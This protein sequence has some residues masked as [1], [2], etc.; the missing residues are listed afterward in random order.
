MIRLEKHLVNCGIDT[1]K[2]IKKIILDGRVTVN[3]EIE[4]A[5]STKIDP[6]IDTILYDGEK[7]FPKTLKYYMMNKP[8]GYIT[9]VKH[10]YGNHIPIMD[11]F[12]NEI[13]KRGFSPVGRLDKDTEGLLIITNDGSLNH[14]MMYPDKKTEKE[15][16]VEL[17][18][19]IGED[20]IRELENGVSFKEEI[21]KPGIVTVV[22]EKCILLVITEGKYHQ[23]KNMMKAVGNRVVY[24]KRVRIGNLELGNLPLGEVREIRR[25]EII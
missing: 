10:G 22:N 6:E 21:Y 12:P 11:I 13:D 20:S 7:I 8:A 9:A 15:Y 17:D 19:V 3:G 18:R 24:L 23:V 5:C 4:R 25:E 2:A 1:G 16:L 14:T